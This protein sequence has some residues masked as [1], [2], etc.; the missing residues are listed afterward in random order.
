M[1]D[2]INYLLDLATESLE[3]ARKREYIEGLE[4]ESSKQLRKHFLS[5]AI[6]AISAAECLIGLH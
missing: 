6:R 1:K 5:Q 2:R 4:T 3:K